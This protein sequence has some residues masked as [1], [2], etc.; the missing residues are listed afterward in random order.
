MPGRATLGVRFKANDAERWHTIGAA[1][2]DPPDRWEQWTNAAEAG[3]LTNVGVMRP[4]AAGSGRPDTKGKPLADCKMGSMESEHMKHTQ[5]VTNESGAG[6]CPLSGRRQGEKARPY[7]SNQLD[8]GGG[9]EQTARRDPVLSRPRSDRHT[10]HR[11]P[12]GPQGT[13]GHAPTRT[14][15]CRTGT[16][17]QRP[18]P[19]H[20]GGCYWQ[21][22]IG[23]NIDAT[24]REK[25]DPNQTRNTAARVGIDERARADV[26]GHVQP[27]EDFAKV[28]HRNSV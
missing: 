14:K 5:A 1:L 16:Q 2:G 17:A 26:S 6:K 9:R 8:G 11:S 23:P 7:F 21:R 22:G 18:R 20:A 13:A 24:L 3:L 28:R 12:H 10:Q 27:T 19:P 25:M 15:W 4:G